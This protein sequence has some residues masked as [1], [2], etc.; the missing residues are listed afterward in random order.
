MSSRQVERPIFRGQ[1]S[2]SVS[3]TSLNSRQD[4]SDGQSTSTCTS[5]QPPSPPLPLVQPQPAQRPPPAPSLE[6]TPTPSPAPA[7]DIPPVVIRPSSPPPSS[8]IN[9]TNFYS[10]ADSYSHG[11]L[12]LVPP[13]VKLA[14]ATS[15]SSPPSPSHS[16]SL[17]G[18]DPPSRG[19]RLSTTPISFRS[20]S[21]DLRTSS[22]QNHTATPVRAHSLA[23]TGHSEV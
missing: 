9:N 22:S 19:G 7:G 10:S 1:L 15:V 16:R 21:D 14:G 20:S 13:W 5:P 17:D 6:T 12:P 8:P 18:H 4:A 3:T 23:L 2:S 11:R